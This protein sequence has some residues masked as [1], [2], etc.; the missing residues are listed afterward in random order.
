MVLK[1]SKSSATGKIK[2]TGGKKTSLRTALKWQLK[3]SPLL[4]RKR[5]AR[6][7]EASDWT[8]EHQYL[9]GRSQSI[10]CVVGASLLIG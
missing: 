10:D 7:I 5:D 1:F 3:K 6:T 9:S 2:I 4:Y 8:K